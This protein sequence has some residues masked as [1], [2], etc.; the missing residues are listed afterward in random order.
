VHPQQAIQ[1]NHLSTV[2][3]RVKCAEEAITRF[4]EQV[5]YVEEQIFALEQLG[6]LLKQEEYIDHT[7]INAVLDCLGRTNVGTPQRPVDLINSNANQSAGAQTGPRATN[8]AA[9]GVVGR[10]NIRGNRRR[11]H[12]RV[13]LDVL[14]HWFDEHAADP[15]PSPE[16]K[17]MLS[18]ETQMEVRQVEQCVHMTPA[19][20]RF[21]VLKYRMLPVCKSEWL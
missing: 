19:T 21:A 17:E 8:Q 2:L 11:N 7:R 12:R 15:Y 13:Q 14:R 10:P 1:N 6:Q 5:R 16:E 9:I 3:A 20:L 18:H 4:E